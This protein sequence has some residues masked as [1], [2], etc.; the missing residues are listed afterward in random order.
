[1][2]AATVR[3]FCCT[4]TPGRC[5][6]LAVAMLVACFPLGTAGSSVAASLRMG[7]QIP[8]VVSPPFRDA[9]YANFLWAGTRY[10]LSWP[11][12]SSPNPTATLFDDQ[13][14]KVTAISRAGCSPDGASVLGQAELS[15]VAFD[16][17]SSRGTTSPELYSPTT[18]KWLAVQPSPGI[19]DVCGGNGCT[20]LYHLAGAG[21]FWLQYDLETS[22]DGEHYTS[23]NVFQNLQTGELRQDPTGGTTIADLN[24]PSLTAT[25]CRPLTV[26]TAL[27]Q[28]G[29]PVPGSLRFYGRFAVSISGDT[30]SDAYLERCG[31]HLHRF[32]TNE[33][34]SSDPS[35]LVSANTHEVVWVAHGSSLNALTL[36]GLR[37]FT[38]RLPP[39][40][41]RGCSDPDSC[42]SQISLTDRRLYILGG[43]TLPEQ[44]WAASAP[45]PPHTK[46]A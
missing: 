25:V 45:L 5:V 12:R 30:D 44:L 33:T 16:C 41:A 8:P 34:D 6:A 29:T 31:S 4:Q 17:A 19:S 11:S 3:S 18:G 26:P 10:A 21:R 27:N 42:I 23:S 7:S 39:Q 24:A 43:T 32:L 37:P 2:R 46:H 1:M 13:T 38:I 36:P 20:S 35:A 9:G 40:V 14:G 15:W 22:T 28:Y